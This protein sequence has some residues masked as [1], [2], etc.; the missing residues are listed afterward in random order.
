[1]G[2]FRL[3]LNIQDHLEIT[4]KGKEQ[5]MVMMEKETRNIWKLEE[6]GIVIK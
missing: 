2:I 1:M 6:K 4:R 5:E 3:D